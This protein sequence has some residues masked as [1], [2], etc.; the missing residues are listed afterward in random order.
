MFLPNQFVYAAS[1]PNAR[2]QL[3]LRFARID[4]IVVIDGLLN[5]RTRLG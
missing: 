4:E 1:Q 5:W 2:A 3:L